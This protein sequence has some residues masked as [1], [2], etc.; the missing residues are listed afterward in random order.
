MLDPSEQPTLEFVFS[1]IHPYD[2]ADFRLANER[3]LQGGGRND[4]EIRCLM[5]DDAIKHIH[6]V[7]QARPGELGVLEFLGAMADVTA[8]SEAER[9]LQQAQ[10]DL[11]HV[12]RL[13]TL[14]ELTASIAHEVNQPLAGVVINGEACLR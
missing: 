3:A 13:T 5:P 11:A 6:A 14:G 4:F 10:A 2:V 1:R 9:A 7:A 12:T 8:A